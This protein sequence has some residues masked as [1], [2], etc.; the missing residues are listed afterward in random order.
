MAWDIAQEIEDGVV[1]VNYIRT[2]NID[3]PL[4]R[5]AADGT[6]RYYQ[7]D[8]LGSIVALTDDNGIVTTQYNY[9]PFGE[10]SITEEIS[11]NPFQYTGRENDGTGLYYYRARYYNPAMKRFISEDPIG[12]WG[13][14]VNFYAYVGNNPVNW[15]D[16]YGL[17]GWD[18]IGRWFGKQAAKQIGKW[19]GKKIMPDKGLNMPYEGDDD[20]D[21]TLNFMDPD[22]E[23]C[24]VNCT[25]PS[26]PSKCK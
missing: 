23:Y 3:E 8:A 14:D 2:L 26:E 15:V 17:L 16:P 4:V 9:T 6:V 12:F 10:A 11:D 5:I 7:S 20:N 19:F 21:G 24:Q 1:S 18:T 25:R 13:G 22:S